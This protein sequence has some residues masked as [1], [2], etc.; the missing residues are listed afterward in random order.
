MTVFW[1]SKMIKVFGYVTS[2]PFGS[3]VMPVPAQ[4]SCIREYCK[5]IGATYVLP[6]L[7]HKFQ[8]CFMQLYTVGSNVRSGDI[9]A[10]YSV[11]ILLSSNKAIKF[12][13]ELVSRGVEVHFVLENLHLSDEQSLEELKSYRL[14]R[15]GVI[16]RSKLK[17]YLN[18]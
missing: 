15:K 9:I 7:E 13:S 18:V 6:P 17:Q 8:N 4:N 2:R 10:M 12:M 11:E 5:N 14:F 16:S 3:F 1:F